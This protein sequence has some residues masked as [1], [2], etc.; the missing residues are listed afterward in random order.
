MIKLFT[1]LFM[2]FSVHAYAANLQPP[3][4]K[5][6]EA[7]GIPLYPKAI[8]V[9]GSKDVG[10]RF[11]TSLPPEDAQ[12]W[13]GQQLPKWELYTLYGAW[14]IYNGAPARGMAEVM[15]MNHISIQ[16]N[17][18]LPE[19]FSLNKNMTTEIVIVIRK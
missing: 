17:E 13:Y 10:F 19:W 18:N 2:I 3:D 8:F 7:A 14:I 1:L 12:E 15:S 16:Y 4:S 9:N 6:I 5:L 11:V